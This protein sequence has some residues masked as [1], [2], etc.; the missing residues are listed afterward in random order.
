MMTF[1]APA[2]MWAF[3]GFLVRNRPVDSMT[4]SAP[5]SSHFSLAGVLHRGQADLAVDDQGVALDGDVTLEAAV[6]RVVLE[7]VRR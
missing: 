7:H 1:L 5:T 2:A 6:H 3:G 4:M